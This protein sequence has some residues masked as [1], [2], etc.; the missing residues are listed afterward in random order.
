MPV[1]QHPVA[2]PV[3]TAAR[4]RRLAYADNLKVVL[5]A[6]VIVGHATIAWTGVGTWVLTEPPVR[7]PM[8]SLLK[9]AAAIGVLF[10]MPLFF[11]IAGAFTPGSL[12]RKG[13]RRFLGDRTVRLGIPMVAFVLVLS[14]LVEY[15]DTDNA[16][17]SKGFPAFAVHIWWPPAPGPT[18]F[19]GVLLVFSAVYALARTAFPRRVTPPTPVR[20]RHLLVAGASIAVV[21]YAVR[22]AVP[23]GEEHWHLAL[24]QAPAWIVGF[25]LGVVGGERGWFDR[26]TPGMSRGLR[27]VAWTAAALA[28]LFVAAVSAGGGDLED[29]AGGGTWQSLATAVIEGA[30]AVAMS[31]WLLDVFRRRLN[32]LGPLAHAMSRAAFAAFLVHQ[33]ILVGL[34]LAGRLVPWPPEVAYLGVAALAVVG[35]FGV[36]ALLVRLPGVSRVV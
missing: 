19:L 12:A 32:H 10:A 22:F 11:L 18:W 1:L 31:L 33:A 28:A 23:I 17:W 25:I 20:P 7:E 29:L 14:P 15:A 34:I 2:T 24:G 4:P 35:S 5:V 6:G 16:G 27:R 8:L 21:S 9:T 3:A 13:L 26:I 36:G 30:I